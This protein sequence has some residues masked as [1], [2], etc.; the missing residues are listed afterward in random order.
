MTSW[1][2]MA[3]KCYKTVT[4]DVSYQGVTDVLISTSLQPSSHTDSDRYSSLHKQLSVWSIKV[5]LHFKLG[6]WNSRVVCWI[7][8]CISDVSQIFCG[9]YTNPC[10]WQLWYVAV[11][12]LRSHCK[13]TSIHCRP[14]SIC[15]GP[16]CT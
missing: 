11:L 6:C 13:S 2:Q 12:L 4:I 1:D 15:Q 3:I 14:T 9:V 10:N 7:R 16:S 8:S 5:N